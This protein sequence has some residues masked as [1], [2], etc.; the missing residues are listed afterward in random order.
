MAKRKLSKQQQQRIARQQQAR[1]ARAAN[2]VP[3]ADEAHLGPEQEGL[4][5]TQFGQQ[6]DVENVVDSA[7]APG[8]VKRCFLRAN[9]GAVVTGDKVV[10]RDS[11]REGVVVSVLPRRSQLARP[12]SFGNMKI[13]AANIDRLLITVALQPEPHANLIDR[14]LVVAEI[15]GLEAVLLVNKIDLGIDGKLKNLLVEYRALGYPVLEISARTRVGMAELTEQISHGISVFVG[16][17]G[18]G[19]SSI[20]QK[21]LPD[22]TIRVGELSEQ[23]HKG[24]H[25]TTH[26]RLYH[27]PQGGDCIDSPGIRE[28][29]LWHMTPGEVAAGFREFQPFLGHCRFRDCRHKTDPGCALKT[30]VAEGQLS[31]ARFASFMHIVDSLDAVDVRE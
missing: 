31:A 15:L 5:I 23:V 9:L 20:I 7:A 29:G 24:R 10:W 28:F 17:S 12:D 6:V 25:T 14:Y 19:K 21:L 26:S 13:V 8:L 1:A 4:I 16:Q 11:E 18:T 22:E 30:A 27:F 3:E 2:P